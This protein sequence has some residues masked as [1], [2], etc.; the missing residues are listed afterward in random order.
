VLLFTFLFST[1]AICFVY[2]DAFFFLLS[3]CLL[4]ARCNS[5]DDCIAWARRLF[6]DRFVVKIQQ[7]RCAICCCCRL[8]FNFACLVFV[9]FVF[10]PL[11]LPLGALS[12][13]SFVSLFSCCTR[14]RWTTLTSMAPRSGLAPSDRQSLSPTTPTTRP[15]WH[16]WW[17]ELSSRRTRLGSVCGKEGGDCI[18]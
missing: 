8:N 12:S 16:S 11:L 2:F 18:V 9:F 17:L 10:Y 7:V 14:F 5:F 3:G 6:E 15:T 1:S 4:T 13:L